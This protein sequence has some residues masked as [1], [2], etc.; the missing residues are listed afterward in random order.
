MKWFRYLLYFILSLFTLLSFYFIIS[1]SLLFFP[2]NT[3]QHHQTQSDTRIFYIF[4]DFAHTEIILEAKDL[5]PELKRSLQPFISDITKGYIA[6]SYGDEA[7]MFQ[8]PRWRDIQISLALKALFINTPAVIRVGHYPSIRHDKTI[9]TLKIDNR[10][11]QILQHA[12]LQS[13]MQKQGC[14]IP[15]RHYP[16]NRYIRYFRARKPYNLFYTCNTW[17]G[18]MLRSAA[19]PLSSWTPLSFQVVF[20]FLK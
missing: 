2:A 5:I 8:T 4:H 12:I 6:F 10:R 9:I 7:F 14:L 16:D 3:L 13:F 18:D 20:H 17:S 19:L 15:L 11:L 1:S